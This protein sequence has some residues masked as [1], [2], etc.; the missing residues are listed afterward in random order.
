M[1]AEGRA[2]RLGQRLGAVNDEQPADL[3]IET[4]LDQIVDESLHDGGV[5]GGAFDEAKR[6]LVPVSVDPQRGDQH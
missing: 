1:P 5:L 4:A 3:W 2:D 6:M